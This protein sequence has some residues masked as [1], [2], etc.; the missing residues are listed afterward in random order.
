M[1][2]QDQNSA[3]FLTL[4]QENKHRQLI[5]DFESQIA[6]VKSAI[7][8]I[9]GFQAFDDSSKLM[10]AVILTSDIY[11]SGTANEIASNFLEFRLGSLFN[12]Q[13]GKRVTA[14]WADTAN[15]LLT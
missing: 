11:I 4:T 14:F 3:I 8:P 7:N 15:I 10:Y 13:E 9:D 1:F 6:E 2:A 5:I 12:I